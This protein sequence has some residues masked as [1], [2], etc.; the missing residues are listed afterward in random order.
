MGIQGTLCTTLSNLLAKDFKTFKFHLRTNK[1][2]EFETIPA[3]ELEGAKETTDLVGLIVQHY[4]EGKAGQATVFFLKKTN[5]N[6]LAQKLQ[7]DLEAGNQMPR[8]IAE[9]RTERMSTDNLEKYDLSAER[10]GYILCVIKG[11]SGAKEDMIN[12]RKWYKKF[13]INFSEKIDPS[14]KEIIPAFKKFRDEINGSHS[15][16]SCCVI[17]V[18]AHGGKGGLIHGTDGA[19]NAPNVKDIFDLFNNVQCP[20]LQKRPKVFIIQACRGSLR[21]EGVL[22]TDDQDVDMFE[23]DNYRLPTMCDTFTVYPTQPGFVAMRNTGYGSL[24]IKEMM[25]V[26]KDFDGK[27]HLYDIFV[28]INKRL[29]QRTFNFEDRPVKVTLVIESTLTEPLYL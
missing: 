5:Q 3:S 12:M 9:E 28:K 14:G 20:K 23:E 25:E 24:M 16:V 29:T 21:D 11:R 22:Q 17:T 15:D 6:D 18:M 27:L 4:T 2:E 26:F 8:A 10:R 1:F 19:Q 7:R 13:N